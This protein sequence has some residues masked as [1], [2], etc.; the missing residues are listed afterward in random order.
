MTK[1]SNLW[2]ELGEAFLLT[3]LSLQHLIMGAFSIKVVAHCKESTTAL[4]VGG[5]S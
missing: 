3:H 1:L 4:A 2:P 5:K